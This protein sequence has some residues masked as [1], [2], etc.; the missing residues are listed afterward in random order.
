MADATVRVSGPVL[1][2]DTRRG[3]S[4]ASGEPYAITTARVLVESTGVSDVTLPDTLAAH[5]IE[6]QAVDL[7]CDVS[8]YGNKAQLRAVRDLA[9]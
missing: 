7:L 2:L 5:V 6:G 3:T 1:M 4:R 8:V 9:L